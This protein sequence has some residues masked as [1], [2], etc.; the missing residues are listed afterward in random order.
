MTRD[1]CF[2]TIST[3][4][5]ARAWA[6]IGYWDIK[7]DSVPPRTLILASQFVEE[8]ILGGGM[9]KAEFEEWLLAIP[10]NQWAQEEEGLVLLIRK[11]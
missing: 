4:Y 2:S 10:E 8:S 3:V 6:G 7:V 11:L 5:G 1:D 9:T